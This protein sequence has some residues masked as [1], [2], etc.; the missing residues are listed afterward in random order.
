M[1]GSRAC[2]SS[3]SQPLRLIRTSQPVDWHL[4]ASLSAPISCLISTC[5]HVDQHLSAASL[6]TVSQLIKVA[7]YKINTQKSLAFL[8]T[9]NEKTER[10]IKET[11]PFTIATERIK[12]LGIYLCLPGE[13]PGQRS[14]VGFSARGHKE[15][16]MTEW[17][18]LLLSKAC[19]YGPSAEPAMGCWAPP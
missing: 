10:E 16:D 8:Y 14:L 2:F 9:N 15:Q 7:G 1:W 6:A 4:S 18:T 13:F 11:I 3:K 5:Q 17:L 19:T 12:Y